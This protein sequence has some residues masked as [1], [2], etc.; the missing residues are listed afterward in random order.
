[1]WH[2]FCCCH[3]FFV[4]LFLFKKMWLNK[5]KSSVPNSQSCEV[6]DLETYHCAETW[7]LA[8]L[9]ARHQSACLYFFEYVYIYVFFFSLFFFFFFCPCSSVSNLSLY[10]YLLFFHC[11]NG[12]DFCQGFKQPAWQMTFHLIRPGQNV[13]VWIKRESTVK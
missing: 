13:L 6:C 7:S 8:F 1:M 2:W 10:I 3:V 4:F 11:H 9:W 5:T 12:Q